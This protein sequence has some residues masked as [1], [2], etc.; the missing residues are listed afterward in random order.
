MDVT[1]T[2]A[3]VGIFFGRLANFVNAELYGKISDVPWAVKYPHMQFARHPSQIYE[4]LLEGLL[5][6]IILLT[7]STKERIRKAY[8]TQASSWCAMRLPAYLW[9]SSESQMHNWDI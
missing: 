6:L 5:L 8:G 3:P 1:A 9:N 4:A 2:I 7:L